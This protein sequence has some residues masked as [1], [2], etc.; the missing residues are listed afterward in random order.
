LSG[1]GC[2]SLGTFALSSRNDDAIYALFLGLDALSWIHV[3][4]ASWLLITT[5]TLIF[6]FFHKKHIHASEIA[7]DEA[8]DRQARKD[9]H[10]H[11][12]G[13]SSHLHPLT[14]LA[15]CYT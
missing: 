3:I 11:S 10:Y 9:A 12:M 2:A 7:E 5:T 8:H 14:K 4:S 1:S 15:F 13:K 6:S